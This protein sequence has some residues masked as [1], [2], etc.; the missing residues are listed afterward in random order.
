MKL[1]HSNIPNDLRTNT[2]TCESNVW[3]FSIKVGWD[4]S[5]ALWILTKVTTRFMESLHVLGIVFA[6]LPGRKS[7]CTGEFFF[8]DIS[9]L[10]SL[11]LVLI[12]SVK[13]DGHRGTWTGC[14]SFVKVNKSKVNYT[15]MFY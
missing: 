10:K 13:L 3:Q 9:P 4:A 14:I 7:T 2:R 15:V 11:D 12:L 8:F 5:L 1:G 6:Y